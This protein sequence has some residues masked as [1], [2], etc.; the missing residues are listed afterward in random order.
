MG[1]RREGRGALFIQ[2]NFKMDKSRSCRHALMR[3]WNSLRWSL[4]V[5]GT[6]LLFRGS[7]ITNIAGRNLG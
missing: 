1:V 7:F 4:A 5:A 2:K 6:L 3:F